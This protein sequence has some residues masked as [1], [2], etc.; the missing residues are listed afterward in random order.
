MC[1][2][3]PDLYSSRYTQQDPVPLKYSHGQGELAGR[4]LGV[5][6]NIANDST[7]PPRCNAPSC[8]YSGARVR[9]IRTRNVAVSWVYI[10]LDCLD[11]C[12]TFS[13]FS[14]L[15][16]E[17]VVVLLRIKDPRHQNLALTLLTT[18]TKQKKVAGSEPPT[19]FKQLPDHPI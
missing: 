14:V 11:A 4:G 7:P 19:A 18:A 17:G 10:G 8:K 3:L 2:N 16:G 1:G 15:E 6:F 13:S 5:C 9:D 12:S